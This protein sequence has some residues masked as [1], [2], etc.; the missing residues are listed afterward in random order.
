MLSQYHSDVLPRR[1][2]PSPF[3]LCFPDNYGISTIMYGWTVVESV[4]ARSYVI[5]SGS[6]ACGGSICAWLSASS[7]HAM[8][9][10]ITLIRSACQFTTILIDISRSKISSRWVTRM[11]LTNIGIKSIFENSIKCQSHKSYWS[12]TTPVYMNKYVSASL[13]SFSQ[14][15]KYFWLHD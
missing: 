15:Q 7:L 13:L 4:I 8:N 9:F 10:I 6:Y 2:Q 3:M 5:T 14:H 1:T 11:I 12:K